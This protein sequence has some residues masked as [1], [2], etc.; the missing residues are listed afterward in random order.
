MTGT[1]QHVDRDAG[2]RSGRLADLVAMVD[3]GLEA[4]IGVGASLDIRLAELTEGRSV[5]TLRP[6]VR[7][8][9]TQFT[10]HGGVLATLMDTAMGSAVY[11]TLP[12]R[13]TYTTAELSTKFV[14]AVRLNDPDVCCE[15][16]VVHLGR[17]TATAECRVLSADGAVVAHGSCLCLL[18]PVPSG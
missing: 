11:A 12:A 4:G 18:F 17:Q 5:W 10:V 13:T 2:E 8:A 3:Y 14:R 7:A 16:T 15:A 6:S 9:S 1:E